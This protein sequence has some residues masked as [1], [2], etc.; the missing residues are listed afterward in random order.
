MKGAAKGGGCGTDG[1]VHG[2]VIAGSLRSSERS[3]RLL[4]CVIEHG[5]FSPLHQKGEGLGFFG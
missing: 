5:K 2:T 1:F 4:V 3:K